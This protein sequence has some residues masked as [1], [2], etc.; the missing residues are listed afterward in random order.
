MAEIKLPISQAQSGLLDLSVIN[1]RRDSMD[2]KSEM[3]VPVKL[4]GQ[5]AGRTLTWDAFIVR[6]DASIDERN[7]LQ[8]L[9]AQVI[10]PYGVKGELNEKAPLAMGTFVEAEI[11]GRLLDD[12]YVLPRSALHDQNTVWLLDASLKLKQRDVS[13]VYR[14]KSNIYISEGLAAGDRVITSALDTV[15]DGMQ[16]RVINP[17]NL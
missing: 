4:Y 11:S 3:S 16:L 6:T 17:E 7:R 12:I 8:N 14:G 5:Y 9:I 15:I 13:I 10:D 1:A 2:K